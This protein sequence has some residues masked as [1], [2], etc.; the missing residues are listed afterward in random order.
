MTPHYTRKR[1]KKDGSV[2]R[3]AYYRCTKTMPLTNSACTIRHL[4]ADH[5]E[6][7]V[8]QHLLD[9]SQNSP[10]VTMS[11]EELN[12]DQKKK[13]K[14]LEQ[15]AIRFRA[16]LDELEREIGRFVSALGQGT[17]SVKRLDQEVLQRGKDMAVLQIQY[18]D[19]QKRIREQASRDYNV[20]VVL[21]NLQ[22]FRRIF[23]ALAP[24]EQAEVL[25]YLVKDV[26]VYPNKLTFNIFELAELTPNSKKRKDWP[27]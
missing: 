5:A 17:I 6:R 23:D 4:N 27:A 7:M 20:E 10:L 8:I 22:D 21:R 25:H 15:E 9:L 11:V 26:I 13:V 3:I 16:R 12:R 14:P 19:V 18:D 2:Y 1:R 24:Q